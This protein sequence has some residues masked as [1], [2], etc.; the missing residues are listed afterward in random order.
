MDADSW[1]FVI[2]IMDFDVRARMLDF[3]LYLYVKSSS[4]LDQHVAL[5]GRFQKHT[6]YY[7]HEQRFFLFLNNTLFFRNQKTTRTILLKPFLSQDD[8]NNL[9]KSNIF[10]VKFFSF[11]I[12]KKI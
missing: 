3:I 8:I 5:N 2:D 1:N 6:N 12:Y 7:L 4:V 9:E 10:K 11:K